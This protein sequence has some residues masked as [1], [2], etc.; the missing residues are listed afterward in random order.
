MEKISYGAEA[1]IFKINSNWL[2]KKRIIQEY[3]HKNL[4]LKLRTR[5]TRREFKVIDKLYES[6]V[7]VP[8]V[9]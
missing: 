4:D 6:G 1:E 2:L 7:N 5:R 9:Q 3:R 8:K